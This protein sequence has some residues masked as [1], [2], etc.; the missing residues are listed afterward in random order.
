MS[1]GV[2]PHVVKPKKHNVPK[3]ETTA[4]VPDG[5]GFVPST[6][7]VEKTWKQRLSLVKADRCIVRLLQYGHT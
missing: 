4:R 6:S 7:G 2:V 5:E 1:L 3:V